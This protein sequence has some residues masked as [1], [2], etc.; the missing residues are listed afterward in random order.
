M[1]VGRVKRVQDS[2]HGLMEFKGL[3]TFIIEVLRTPELQRL[4]KIRQLGMVHYVF[5]G[6]EHSRLTHSLGAAHLALRFGHQIQSEAG[7]CF[8]SELVPD[9]QALSDLGLAALCHDLGHGPL[10]HAWEREIVGED[11]D[12]Q[13]WAKSFGIQD[14][15]SDIEKM[16]WHELVGYG[17][18][19]WPEGQLHKLL[20]YNASDQPQRI[21]QLLCGR[22]YVPYL[23]KL[24]SSEI[25]VDR[26]DFVQRDTHYTGVAYGRYDLGWLISTCT[27]GRHPQSNQWCV[28]FDAQKSIRVIE[29]FLIARH[30]MY[31]TVYHHRTVRCLEGMVARLLNRLKA[32]ATNIDVEHNEDFLQSTIKLLKGEVLSPNEF[33]SLDD[34]SVF[35]LI[36]KVANGL[37]K[38]AVATDL[39]KRI[40]TRTLFKQ[41]PISS[42]ELQ[43]FFREQED[44]YPRIDAAIRPFVISD[45]KYYRIIDTAK[46]E[47]L[48][49]KSEDAFMLVDKQARASFGFDHPVF[50][51]YRN[52]KEE[53]VRLFVVREAVEAVTKV[54]HEHA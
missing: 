50:R 16:K 34:F 28:G 2:V 21:Q 39:A 49:S 36:D 41:V 5:P 13:A 31:D 48:S 44:A 29:Q 22:Y 24:L 45:P 35:V 20:K 1:S 10:S 38:D 17:L 30:A 53:S 40:L 14:D 26:A 3:E 46:L 32:N 33:L 25:D 12:R 9:E 42:T 43:D 8:A 11:F 47:T 51:R 6:A 15:I 7:K 18:L 27:L 54:I 19:T 23:P 37:F 52:D 4:R